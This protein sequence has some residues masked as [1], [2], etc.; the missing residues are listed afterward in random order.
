MRR[1]LSVIAVV[2][3]AL[4]A[5]ACKEK[6]TMEKAGEA[7]DNAVDDV[8]DAGD[9]AMENAG[10]KMDEAAKKAKEAAGDTH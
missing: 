4:G 10:E 8:K 3:L 6:G 2:G 7:V 9:G 1:F 5:V